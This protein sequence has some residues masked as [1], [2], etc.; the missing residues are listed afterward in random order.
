MRGARRCVA[1][2]EGQGLA[3]GN[4]KNDWQ[5]LSI[6][7]SLSFYISLDI[8]R[9]HSIISRFPASV[10]PKS[11]LTRPPPLPLFP[12]P[13]PRPSDTPSPAPPLVP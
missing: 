4:E 5:N 7:S 11:S 2:W 6:T 3:E 8:S 1:L 10:L 12:P 13:T 9:F